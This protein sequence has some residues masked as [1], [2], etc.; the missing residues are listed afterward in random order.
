[1]AERLL[2]VG[3][4][5]RIRSFTRWLGALLALVVL[6]GLA[7]CT[8]IPRSGEVQPGDAIGTDDDIDVV[9]LAE[10]PTA[11]ASQQAILNGFIQ[12]AKSPQDDYAIARQYLTSAAAASWKPNEK[13]LVDSGTRPTSRGD[14]L[15]L[16]LSATP[17][18]TVDASGI[19]AASPSSAPTSLSFGFTQ[20]DGEWRISRL[21]D[22]TVIE[23]V[24]FDQIFSS[25]ALYYYDPTFAYLVPDLR[26]FATSSA[27]GTRVVKALLKGPVAWLGNGAVVTAFP[28]GTSTTSVVT[29]SGQT[30]VELSS[31]VLQADE[32]DLRRMQAQL[33]SSLSGLASAS[34]VVIS[35]DQNV[36]P[37]PGSDSNVADATP[38][39]N[40]LPLV[41][42]EGEF[43]Y[44]SGG[45]VSP[46]DGI[47]E[48]VQ[49]VQPQS[50]AYSAV[51]G[52][53]AVKAGNGA[54]V[55]VRE[56]SNGVPIV[57]QVDTRPGLIDP[58]VDPWGY[59]W[60]IPSGDPTAVV[61]AGASNDAPLGIPT[62]W[63]GASSITSF[64]ISRDGTRALAFL[65]VAGALKLVVAAVIRDQNGVPQQL[66]QAVE[67]ATGPGSP[68][69]ATWVDQ[70]SVASATGL[71]GEVRVVAQQLGGRTTNL[72]APASAVS[73]S[74]SND[75]D[76]L[77]VLGTDGSLLQQ[78]GSAWQ[79]TTGGVSELGVQ[80]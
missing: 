31:N 48:G 61:A 74:G 44:L 9:F 52:T 14:D 64:E 10:G 49:S 32:T 5:P 12:A 45:G 3:G 40:S 57:Q 13:T 80:N 39:V 19:Y 26:W 1:M 58:A 7:A 50:A 62:T 60:S 72:G 34:S 35:V 76:G 70:F 2:S 46:I 21:D 65:E 23:D 18:A 17:V 78:R 4:S 24:F 47:S 27:V 37:I 33:R 73:L 79:A 6:A 43:G 20:Q 66:G 77:R 75:L 30:R 67:L 68:I 29:A 42:S 63:D 16:D 11:G 51:S 53:V 71:P 15:T 22:G 59:V 25:Y 54:V 36:V 41:V 56:T 8:G 55:A 38:R 28:E 69:D